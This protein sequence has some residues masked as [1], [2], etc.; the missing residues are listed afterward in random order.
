MTDGLQFRLH[1]CRISRALTVL[2]AVPGTTAEFILHPHPLSLA[3]C[4]YAWV[5]APVVGHAY[6]TTV[7]KLEE[8]DDV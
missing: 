5:W 2:L 4:A 8:V 6:R 3:A 1:A 7:R